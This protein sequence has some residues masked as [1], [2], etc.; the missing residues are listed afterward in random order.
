MT[1]V[2]SIRVEKSANNTN[3]VTLASMLVRACAAA[4]TLFGSVDD[5]FSEQMA[6]CQ[7]PN[8]HRTHRTNPH[9][10]PQALLFISTEAPLKKLHKHPGAALLVR[11]G[12]NTTQAQQPSPLF[13]A[14]R[15]NG[16]SD[17]APAYMTSQ[18][19][20][21]LRSHPLQ[22]VR[23]PHPSCCS[24]TLPTLTSCSAKASSPV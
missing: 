1:N 3:V 16:T 22:L 9:H 12:N 6:T 13:L 14:Y 23:V 10:T 24:T 2:P 20:T 15:G 21:Q 17:I 4:I 18:H 19:L 11:L 5:Q 7:V 8:I